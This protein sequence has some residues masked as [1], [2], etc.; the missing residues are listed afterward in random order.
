MPP[1]GEVKTEKPAKRG[2]R[3][4]RRY[5]V[6][7][8][9]Q[10]LVAL[11]RSGR[12]LELAREA[13]WYR[14]PVK[15]APVYAAT[16]KYLAFYQPKI[17]KTEGWAIRYWAEVRER[18]IVPRYELLPDEVRHERCNE[19]YYKLELGELRR[20]EPPIISRRGRRLVFIPTTLGKFER[21]TEINDLFHDSPLED[22]RYEAFR[23]ERLEAERQFYV[24]VDRRRFCL[25]FALFCQNGKINVEC[26]GDHWHAT[27]DKI[28]EDNERN[29]LLE[30]AGWAVL[31]FNTT[32][33]AEDMPRCLQ[34]VRETA[35]RY[36]GVVTPEG[37][38]R[39]YALGGADRSKQLN[40]FQETVAEYE[41][42]TKSEA[43][44]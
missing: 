1:A 29:N 40:L 39:Y 37:E 28:P 14:I 3:Q 26:D 17:F 41:A 20:R 19:E 33:L 36:G 12:D 42:R 16:A 22:T 7:P 38:L 5:D 11:I 31:R 34:R 27:T 21:A 32:Q 43:G 2:E 10:I 23:E 24:T 4:A 9:E 13:H 44:E 18:S 35:N 6:P 15:S 25:D 30:S 8:S